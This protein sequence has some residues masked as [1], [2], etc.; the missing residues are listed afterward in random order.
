MWKSPSELKKLGVDLES[1]LWCVK[2]RSLNY[3]NLEAV[4]LWK[5]PQEKLDRHIRRK[6]GVI[7]KIVRQSKL[8]PIEKG[9]PEHVAHILRNKPMAA[10]QKIA[11]VIKHPDKGLVKEISSGAKTSGPVS[12][13]GLRSGDPRLVP[14]SASTLKRIPQR[15]QWRL[16][17]SRGNRSLNKKPC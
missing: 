16:P 17:S 4:K 2:R 11:K 10:W 1:S 13:S 6:L 9:H 14:P 12:K 5:G 3:A 7:A 8:G 15:S